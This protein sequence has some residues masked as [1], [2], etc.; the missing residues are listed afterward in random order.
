MGQRMGGLG[1]VSFWSL[2]SSIS[3]RYHVIKMPVSEPII[4]FDNIV[5]TQK[6]YSDRIGLELGVE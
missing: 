1:R 6:E 3:D 5:N 4:S 2:A